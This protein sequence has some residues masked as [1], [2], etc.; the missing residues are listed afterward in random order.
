MT[1]AVLGKEI[2]DPV[3]FVLF[4]ITESHDGISET[5]SGYFGENETNKPK[6]AEGIQINNLINSSYLRDLVRLLPKSKQRRSYCQDRE[7]E[8]VLQEQKEP[9]KYR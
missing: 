2:G 6:V 8:N 9:S 5:P 4:P 7:L 1:R 3:D